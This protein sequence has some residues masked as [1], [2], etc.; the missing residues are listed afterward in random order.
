MSKSTINKLIIDLNAIKYNIDQMRKIS[1]A[2][3]FYAVLKAD[4]YGLGS[5]EIMKAI[6]EKVDGYCVSCV[7]EGVELR[8]AGTKK[9]ILN[10][11]YTP[12]DLVEEASRKKIS[13]SIYDFT[14]AKKIDDLLASLGRT[15]TSHIKLDTG[16]GRLGFNKSEKSIDEIVK[17]SKLKNIRLEG[18]FSHLATADEKDT[19][20]TL[21]QKEKFDHM[22]DKLKER[23]LEFK[24]RHLANDAGFIKHKISYDLVRS[25]ICLYGLYPSNLLKEEGEIDLKECFEWRSKVSFVKSVSKG[26]SI[27]Y[28]RTYIADKDMQVATV[29][30]GYADGYKRSNSNRGF[31]LI[32]GKKLPVIGRVTMDQIMVDVTGVNGVAIG[33]DV[34]LIGKSM[35]ETISADDLADWSETISYEIIT[36][37]SKRVTRI[38][39]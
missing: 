36:S 27:S 18:V 4:A 39:E 23:G 17:I 15:I 26:T 30:V 16:H 14:Y 5:I 33:D 28:G 37:I 38:Y 25:G 1:K 29:A 11:G 13:L 31:V 8:E 32:K 9:E 2:S 6:D 35:D 22:V 19:S 7:E 12:L 20:Y 24:K 21:K 3:L 10:L 34:I